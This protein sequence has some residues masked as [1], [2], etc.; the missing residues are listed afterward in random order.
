[1]F[2]DGRKVRIG[3]FVDA[4]IENNRDK[5]ID[6]VDCEI[7]PFEGNR[8]LDG[9][10][11]LSL[12]PDNN[13]CQTPINRVSRHKAPDHFMQ[14]T[15]SNG[16]SITVTPEHPV[17]VV[18]NG[19][20]TTVLADE[21]EAGVFAPIPTKCPLV[22]SDVSLQIPNS[23]QRAHDSNYTE[24]S[25]PT[26]LDSDFGRLLGYIVSEGHVYY[27]EKN[28]TAEVMIS[29]ADLGIINDADDLIRRIFDAA[30]SIRHQR[31]SVRKTDNASVDDEAVTTD[32]Y[33]VRCASI[34]LY[35][36]MKLNFEGVTVRSDEKRVPDQ[37]FASYDDVRIEFLIGA[38]RGDGF[39]DSERFGYTT[40]SIDLA[41]DYSDLLLCLG[42][43]SCITSSDEYG[44]NRY[45]VVVSGYGSRQ[46]FYDAIGKHDSRNREIKKFASGRESKLNDYNRVP[47]DIAIRV[48]TQLRGYR[49]Y[50]GHLN[51]SEE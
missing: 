25:F 44:S 17:Y 38:F 12:N 6:G 24:I 15:Y 49:L 23:R 2:S 18:Q 26:R 37:I 42:I 33:T 14:I 34:P 16:R 29:N 9:T 51:P 50:R 20:I 13:I 3:E 46:K 31:H 47:V 5:T 43:Y 7:L 28:D 40:N 10:E 36:F 39:C 41:N 30:T 27:S 19:E 4:L 22:S 11:I 1:M 21:L 48:K 45:K 35:D 32:L 8:D